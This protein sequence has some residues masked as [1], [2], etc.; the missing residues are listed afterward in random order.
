MIATK[1]TMKGAQISKSRRYMN[2]TSKIDGILK[3]A[4]D[5]TVVPFGTI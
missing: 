4:K 1:L 5:A 3:M 2:S